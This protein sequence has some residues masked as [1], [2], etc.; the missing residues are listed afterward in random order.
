MDNQTTILVVE[1]DTHIN[2]MVTDLL[3]QNDYQA[4][5]A[6]SGTEAIL[7]FE[8]YKF[9]LIL[10]DL[11]L[12]GLAGEEVLKEIRENSDIPII[13]VTA[14]SDKTT[15]VNLL[16]E[17]ADDYIT[18]PFNNSELLARIEAQIRRY[19]QIFNIKKTVPRITYKD[20]TLDLESYAVYIKNEEV[21]LT[22]REF[23]LLEL[24]MKHPKK[25]Y[26]KANLYEAIWND[27]YYIDD[28]TINVHM[29]NLRTKLAAINPTEEY[30]ETVWG[31]G[32]K[33]VD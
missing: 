23:K 21:N 13:G 4:Y 10:L 29:S 2:Q 3:V 8:Q 18:K 30:I 11:M 27:D 9:D 33:M 5:P 24:L 14:K 25:V 26:T 15:T 28:N 1:D 20:L 22:K 16:K 31:I 7:L 32:F 6:Y 19:N 12:P 17:G